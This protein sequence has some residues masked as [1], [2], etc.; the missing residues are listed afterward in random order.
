MMY[1]SHLGKLGH[2]SNEC[3][4]FDITFGESLL[5]A[6]VFTNLYKRITYRVNRSWFDCHI[7]ENGT[8]GCRSWFL[9]T[10]YSPLVR[11]SD[12]WREEILKN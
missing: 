11:H 3:Q 7:S 8:K 6:S 9:V 5:I 10:N 2:F 4:T 1:R 12:P